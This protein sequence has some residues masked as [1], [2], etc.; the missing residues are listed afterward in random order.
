[1][2]IFIFLSLLVFIISKYIIYEI[3]SYEKKSIHL[4]NSYQIYK[5]ETPSF[6]FNSVNNFIIQL[7]NINY[8]LGYIFIYDNILKIEEKNGVFK[9]YDDEKLIGNSKLFN[10]NIKKNDNIYYIVFSSKKELNINFFIFSYQEQYNIQSNSTF[11]Q[12]FYTNLKYMEWNFKLNLTNYNHIQFTSNFSQNDKISLIIYKDKLKKQK[13]Y[14]I[15]NQTIINYV[16][17][18]IGEFYICL[19]HISNNNNFNKY[20]I[21]KISIYN[22]EFN[23]INILEENK[24]ISIPLHL[25]GNKGIKNFYIDI[26]KY[27][28]DDTITLKFNPNLAS[29]INLKGIFYSF[30]NISLKISNNYNYIEAYDNLDIYENYIN[31]KKTD[32]DQKIYI[33]QI[34]LSQFNFTSNELFNIELTP[35]ILYSNLKQKY[36]TKKKKK[37][38]IVENSFKYDSQNIILF[39][40]NSW[41]KQCLKFIPS[42][43]P[44]LNN[45][46]CNNFNIINKTT[47]LG[48]ENKTLIVEPYSDDDDVSYI[49]FEV[50]F[51]DDINFYYFN[52][53]MPNLE[54]IVK[55]SNNKILIYFKS[56][57]NGIIISKIIY[58]E[59][60]IYYTNIFHSINTT[61]NYEYYSKPINPIFEYKYEQNN[62]LIIICKNP[63]KFILKNYILYNSNFIDKQYVTIPIYIAKNQILEKIFYSKEQF[64][65]TYQL[66][67]INEDKIKLLFSFNDENYKIINQKDQKIKYNNTINVNNFIKLITNK[68]S[69]INIYLGQNYN[70][71]LLNNHSIIYEF[72]YSY[73]EYN[74]VN[75]RINSN[76]S[77]DVLI[78]VFKTFDN[79]SSDVYFFENSSFYLLRKKEYLYFDIDNPKDKDIKN[80]ISLYFPSCFN[81]INYTT[82]YYK[83][84]KISQYK[85]IELLLETNS[86][87]I[88]QYY[89]PKGRIIID[90]K[91]KPDKSIKLY[92]YKEKNLIFNNNLIFENYLKLLDFYNEEQYIIN[93][94]STDFLNGYFYFVF[95]SENN[96]SIKTTFLIY[97]PLGNYS[98]STEKLRLNTLINDYNE[99]FYFKNPFEYNTKYLHYEWYNSHTSLSTSLSFNEMIL[100]KENYFFTD[101]YSIDEHYFKIVLSSERNRDT[102][103]DLFFSFLI[104]LTN[105]TKIK[106]LDDKLTIEVLSPQ[107]I[108]LLNELRNEGK[109]ETIYF[110]YTGEKIE[111]N[112]KIKFYLVGYNDYILKGLPDS[113]YDFEKEMNRTNDD[114]IFSFINEGYPFV[115]IGIEVRYYGF[116]HYTFQKFYPKILI[117][118][119]YYKLFNKNENKIYYI[120]KES[121]SSSNIQILLFSS[122]NNT[123][124]FN[125][126]IFYNKETNI[127]VIS[128]DMINTYEIIEFNV[129][130]YDLNEILYFEIRYLDNKIYYYNNKSRL[131]KINLKVNACKDYIYYVGIYE[132]VKENTILY[133]KNLTNNFNISNNIYYKS[134]IIYKD[135]DSLFIEHSEKDIYKYPFILNSK[136]DL[137]II[138]CS[139]SFEIELNYLKIQK[140]KI[141]F[142]KGAIIPIF[143]EKNKKEK[144]SID[145]FS[146]IINFD[147]KIHLITNQYNKY[148]LNINI[149]LN[150]KRLNLNNEENII[151]IKNY[152]IGNKFISFLNPS[153]DCL[154]FIYILDK[155]PIKIIKNIEKENTFDSPYNIFILSNNKLL[156]K[157]IIGNILIEKIENIISEI[158]YNQDYGDINNISFEKK[159]CITIES[160][161]KIS[162]DPNDY[163]INLNEN[164]SYYVSLYI[165][166]YNK[167][168]YSFNIFNYTQINSEEKIEFKE[169][170]ILSFNNKII[171]PEYKGE[172]IFK[173]DENTLNGNIY[174]YKESKNINIKNNE[175]INYDG[176]I[177]INELNYLYSYKDSDNHKYFFI[178][179]LDNKN[180]I[181]LL[182]YNPVIPKELKIYENFNKIYEINSISSTY[183]FYINNKYNQ[184]NIYFHYQWKNLFNKSNSL[185]II[186]NE[187]QDIEFISKE[188]NE[189][190]NVFKLRN[191]K[192]YI[193][194]K[195]NNFIYNQIVNFELYFYFSSYDKIF[196]LIERDNI[197]EFPIISNQILYFYINISRL[198]F[199]E[200]EFLQ[201]DNFGND[202]T[203]KVKYFEHE[204]FEKMI[205]EDKECYD[206]NKIECNNIECNYSII[207]NNENYKSILLIADIKKNDNILKY[208]KIQLIHYPTFI[209][210]SFTK[211]FLK[212][213]SKLYYIN[214]TSFIKSKYI[215]IRTDNQH[216][217]TFFNSSLHNDLHIYIITEDLL[218]NQNEL[219]FQVNNNDLNYQIEILLFDNNNYNLKHFY[220]D[221][222]TN[223][224]PFLYEINDCKKKNGLIITFL[225]RENN[226]EGIVYLKII[227]GDAKIYYKENIKHIYEI[228]EYDH[229]SE[230][231]Y[232]FDSS[233]TIQYFSFNCSKKTIINFKY[234][235]SILYKREIN[236][237]Q[238]PFYVDINNNFQ[239]TIRIINF[240]KKNFAYKI[241]LVT[242][243]KKKQKI[244]FNFCGIETKLT[245][246]NNIFIN[247]K[248]KIQNYD[249]SINLLDEINVLLL[250]SYQIERFK[251]SYF[252]ESINNIQL[253][254]NYNVFSYFQNEFKN[255]FAVIYIRNISY[256]IDIYYKKIYGNIDYIFPIEDEFIQTLNEKFASF[257]FEKPS[258]EKSINNEETYFLLYF[259]EKSELII[260][261]N[262]YYYEE[263]YNYEIFELN[264]ENEYKIFHFKNI[265]EGEIYIN[266]G[267]KL[268]EVTYIYIYNNKKNI[269]NNKEGFD[270]NYIL[271]ANLS[272]LNQ[273]SFKIEGQD[274]YIILYNKN[275]IKNNNMTIISPKMNY[276][277]PINQIININLINNQNTTEFNYIIN[278]LPKQKFLNI[279][280]IIPNKNLKGL[281]IIN[282]NN[283]TNSSYL[284][285]TYFYFK[286]N[287]NNI[288]N[289]KFKIL[290]QNN[291]ID[292]NSKIKINL[293][294]SDYSNIIL[295]KESIISIPILTPQII[296]LLQSISSY[297][298]NEDIKY[299]IPN[300]K[301]NLSVYFDKEEKDIKKNILNKKYNYNLK[302]NCDNNNNICSYIIKKPNQKYNYLILKIEFTSK[303]D[304]IKDNIFK[305]EKIYPTIKIY[306]NRTINMKKNQKKLIKVYSYH[307]NNDIIILY[308][309][310]ENAISVRNN[311]MI[312]NKKFYIINKEI[313]NNNFVFELYDPINNY[314]IDIKYISDKQFF[315]YYENREI[316]SSY[317]IKF[318][319]SLKENYY[320][321]IFNSEK[322]GFLY[323]ENIYGNVEIYLKNISKFLQ[324]MIY[325]TH[326][327][328]I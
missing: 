159:N 119:N 213:E 151:E 183:I 193:F 8:C 271:T 57:K 236:D 69:L 141:T 327:K 174:I 202:I 232:P 185:I 240:L 113:L 94:N 89:N 77:S 97:S 237:R 23:D 18:G 50:I 157:N 258:K 26:E 320:Y 212:N 59:V 196:P 257:L 118:N 267:D 312:S 304:F 171:F 260:D 30:Y 321:G 286:L 249:I 169:M 163:F 145:Y 251:I 290:N 186:K 175:F 51:M 14:S 206:L 217:I 153:N 55:N 208:F 189:N 130:N 3:K 147:L 53:Y 24:Q 85:T 64:N 247:S 182:I 117:Q 311:E 133:I 204:N 176:I 102:E 28:I 82:Q 46:L 214:R 106:S 136:N 25:I 114:N 253:K 318:N 96:E 1:M 227:E 325:L 19:K 70:N 38:Y 308:S 126:D 90:L 255:S 166:D 40:G 61:F 129:S 273:Y 91:K 143:I 263:I 223:V 301:I 316:I 99:D 268:N 36:S 79:Y 98:I 71:T 78:G 75:L 323:I 219:F 302:K 205:N 93:D 156:N 195:E 180:V 161:F 181:S 44:K 9:N 134:N 319:D 168:K 105:E 283:K 62:L 158:C 234:Y 274:L 220:F 27:E 154:I 262:Y 66:K 310:N 209:S 194:I 54:Y 226:K 177:K 231:L 192:Y 293:Y 47:I 264:F 287:D 5:Y 63:C 155:Y 179:Q 322:Y 275:G 7:E 4:N 83:L 12:Y 115:L 48:I 278:E 281:V 95:V 172:I 122:K 200:E 124:K 266:F 68:E 165:K 222:I 16:Y 297:D 35:F 277:I 140:T 76:L 80:Y 74:F 33:L 279:Q 120:N 218:N 326:K 246:E 109:G 15:Y 315:Y 108:Y 178:I 197:Y 187:N 252:N 272:K 203:Y 265:G 116:T 22:S 233:S 256:N 11:Y 149:E 123:I 324:L 245:N 10:F 229:K 328:I 285:Q 280:W 162:I 238:I 291:L 289:I 121:F 152:N 313:I 250:L 150:N 306:S 86:F 135:F 224:K 101:D 6:I 88:Y 261:Y 146:D 216:K 84:I 184:Q 210:Y 67:V 73:S 81:C 269:H 207:K 211:N 270:G 20:Y 295:F 32:D 215:L 42:V 131:N 314:N 307:S 41:Y 305:I 198:I 21:P 244:I 100:N 45:H 188:M 65:I 29:I 142:N 299:N 191:N 254:N 139:N 230:Y 39:A 317:R 296:Y 144:Y 298:Y 37:F 170:I 309:N 43:V 259:R 110:K 300:I 248:V 173:F 167:F 190:Y 241:E 199:K 148:N 288:Y 201:I 111:S 52:D 72:N 239:Y 276:E 235:D 160:S 242:H 221:L 282:Y 127:F 138:E 56:N 132:E 243:K 292:N 31:I 164:I 13:I 92:I 225:N 284:Y 34:Q 125:H 2:K 60:L 107:I 137:L 104:Y 87:K 49:V 103:N 17:H 294:I 112:P 128:Y 303:I 58:G 228:F